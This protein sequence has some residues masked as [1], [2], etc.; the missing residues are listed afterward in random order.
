L[1]I[2]AG[3]ISGLARHHLLFGV[4]WYYHHHNQLS[5]SVAQGMIKWVF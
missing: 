5:S 1:L 3:A 2:D 4:E